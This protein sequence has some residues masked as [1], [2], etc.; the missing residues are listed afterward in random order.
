M[1]LEYFFNANIG[2]MIC[3]SVPIIGLID[4]SGRTDG[5]VL[6]KRANLLA[7]HRGRRQL[8]RAWILEE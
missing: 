4:Q 5:G 6:D 2:H 3:L 7:L 1:P 8:W